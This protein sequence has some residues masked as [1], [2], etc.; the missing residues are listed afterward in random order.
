MHSLQRP[1]V[2]V[3]VHAQCTVGR[4]TDANE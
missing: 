1:S 2:D 4:D 3:D